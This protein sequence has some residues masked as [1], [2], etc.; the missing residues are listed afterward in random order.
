VVF[1]MVLDVINVRLVLL[2]SVILVLRVVVLSAALLTSS[3]IVL[4]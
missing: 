1:V 2:A 4:G 3:L